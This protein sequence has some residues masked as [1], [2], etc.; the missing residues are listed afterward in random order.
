VV[1]WSAASLARP[2]SDRHSWSAASL[3]RPTSDRHSWSAASLARP[4]SDRHSCTAAFPPPRD[5]PDSIAYRLALGI[6]YDDP[7][8][9]GPTEPF[10]S[11]T[12]PLVRARSRS[13][14][15]VPARS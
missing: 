4:T 13:F 7:R 3:A 5:D 2:T 12:F 10:C 6:G 15:L 9:E 11:P 1:L 14:S 8:P